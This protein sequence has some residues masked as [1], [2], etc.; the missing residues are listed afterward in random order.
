VEA[1]SEGLREE[2]R[3]SRE[4]GELEEARRAGLA[5]VDVAPSSPDGYAVLARSAAAGG[6]PDD[7]WGW[8]ARARSLGAN[9]AAWQEFQASLA[10][11]TRRFGEA[12]GLYSELAEKDPAYAE[13]AE[14]ARLEF[15]IEN[16]P[17]PARKAAHA[18]RLSRAQLASLLWWAVPEV[19]DASAPPSPDV[20]TD[21]VDHP[22]KQALVRAIGLG[23]LSVSRETHHVRADAPFA[24]TEF[25]AV[26]RRLAQLVG[27]GERPVRC[28]APDSGTGALAACGIL[29]ESKSRTVSGKEALRAIERT[30]RMAREGENR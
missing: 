18:S 25:P 14:E 4:G 29:P 26:L 1:Y 17:E 21:V 12:V 23:F 9:D 2:A 15:R 13:K 22:E 20:A 11:K 7:A 27:R 24:R 6:K 10:M 19:R 8:A 3:A 28:L 16:L 30:A 5:L